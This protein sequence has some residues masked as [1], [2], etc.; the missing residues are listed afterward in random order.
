MFCFNEFAFTVQV[1]HKINSTQILGFILICLYF[2]TWPFPHV[3]SAKN[4]AFPFKFL[5]QFSAT[6]SSFMG[7]VPTGDITTK[8]EDFSCSRPWPWAYFLNGPNAAASTEPTLMRHRQSQPHYNH[9]RL[10]FYMQCDVTP[11]ENYCGVVVTTPGRSVGAE[12]NAPLDT[13]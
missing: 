4:V 9:T 11:R 12:F 6:A 7:I 13:V 8:I 3:Y 5:A 10:H 1:K 2:T